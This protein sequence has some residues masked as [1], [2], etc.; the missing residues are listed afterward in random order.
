MDPDAEACEHEINDPDNFFLQNSLI[1]EG[2]G[3]KSQKLHIL[4]DPDFKKIVHHKC[5][6]MGIYCRNIT[7]MKL[8]KCVLIKM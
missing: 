3:S 8:L 5:V 4:A 1:M 7:L 6:D 2:F